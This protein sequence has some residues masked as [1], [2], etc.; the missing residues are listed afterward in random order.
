MNELEVKITEIEIELLDEQQ[1]RAEAEKFGEEMQGMVEI[2]QEQAQEDREYVDEL[3][4]NHK[5]VK[6]ILQRKIAALED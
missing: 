3:Q 5:E 4:C 6:K 1:K 2:L